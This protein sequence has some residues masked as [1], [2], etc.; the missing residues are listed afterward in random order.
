MLYQREKSG[1]KVVRFQEMG[2][3]KHPVPHLLVL[4]YVQASLMLNYHHRVV[5]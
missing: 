4:V 2:L 5:G 1:W 3:T